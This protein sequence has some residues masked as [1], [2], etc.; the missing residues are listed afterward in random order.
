MI[1]Y[2]LGALVAL[3]E[4]VD[5]A[6]I[7]SEY[8]LNPLRIELLQA[9]YG[10]ARAQLSCNLKQA[11]ESVYASIMPNISAPKGKMH[12]YDTKGV[13]YHPTIGP[14]SCAAKLE[15]YSTQTQLK[16]SF[17]EVESK[18]DHLNAC[19]I[20]CLKPNEF[21]QRVEK[22]VIMTVA[23]CNGMYMHVFIYI[24]THIYVFKYKKHAL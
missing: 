13:L 22:T 10:S 2:F 7:H 14:F 12:V 4:I 11:I 15:Y 24:F 17:E 9:L 23:D 21:I 18:F 1:Y 20:D 6:V 3:D 16:S 8:T 5:Q 19:F